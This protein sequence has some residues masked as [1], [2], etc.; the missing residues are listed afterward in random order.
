[1][2][3]LSEYAME[4]YLTEDKHLKQIFHRNNDTVPSYLVTFIEILLEFDCK[5]LNITLVSL[6]TIAYD[7]GFLE[8]YGILQGFT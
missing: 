3:Q 7:L 1:M 5:Q 6:R 4:S 2:Q 8:N